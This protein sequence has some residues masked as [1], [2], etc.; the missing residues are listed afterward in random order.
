MSNSYNPSSTEWEANGYPLRVLHVSED[1]EDATNIFPN[2]FDPDFN[3]ATS[4]GFTRVWEGSLL[5]RAFLEK[6]QRRRRWQQQ[7]QHQQIKDVIT[8]ADGDDE[9]KK[10]TT[11]GIAI[12]E[13]D[14]PSHD[15]GA[16]S[17]IHP[18]VGIDLCVE[19]KNC[20]ELGS[21][22]GMFGLFLAAIGANVLLTDVASVTKDSTAANVALNSRGAV[23][24]GSFFAADATDAVV[25]GDGT[26]ATA[27]IDWVKPLSDSIKAACR[28]ADY[29]V[30]CE[31]VWVP[32]ILA[33]FAATMARLLA[34]APTAARC[35]VCY[36]VRGGLKADAKGYFT[37][38]AQFEASCVAEGLTLAM[39]QFT[40]RDPS[41][42]GSLDTCIYSIGLANET[43]RAH[44]LA[45]NSGA[46]PFGAG[47]A[48]AAAAA[49]VA[50]AKQQ[51]S[52]AYSS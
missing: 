38:Q 21:G 18:T 1:D 14:A 42:K 46:I 41:V 48:A 9:N 16:A 8:N 44:R 5:F 3:A 49:D 2:F 47:S 24:A 7:Q 15:G 28:R 11:N 31:C 52:A 39:L 34:E 43:E 13:A 36:P 22:C 29:I 6:F 45:E 33:P 25:I 50:D 40:A 51:E 37:T 23:P 12:G 30:G 27:P 26:A 10:A 35:L 4:T 20:I 17:S 19:G 32:D